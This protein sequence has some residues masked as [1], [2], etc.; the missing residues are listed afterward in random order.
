VRVRSPPRP[1]ALRRQC[2][3]WQSCSARGVRPSYKPPCA[4][5]GDDASHS[6]T[7]PAA[8]RHTGLVRGIPPARAG[9]L[10]SAKCANR[11]RQDARR[12]RPAR[13]HGP[14]R[15]CVTHDVRG[16]SRVET[17]LIRP[18][19]GRYFPGFRF[20]PRSLPA[21]LPTRT[22]PPGPAA[23]N[24]PSGCHGW[25]RRP[26]PCCPSPGVG[27]RPLSKPRPRPPLLRRPPR[28]RS[29]RSQRS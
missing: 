3:P 27:P 8:Q 28:R 22:L 19:P 29:C 1:Y 23:T 6:T 25:Q 12:E 24:S 11:D 14:P 9:G 5:K 7:P 21:W 26:S 20:S 4:S 2:H 18:G 13:W 10:L 17:G 15:A 16:L